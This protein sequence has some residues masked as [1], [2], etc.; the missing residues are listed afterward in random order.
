MSRPPPLTL[1]S[2]TIVPQEFVQSILSERWADV[3]QFEIVDRS[4]LV[5]ELLR[6]FRPIDCCI[7]N[8]LAVK[9]RARV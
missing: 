2:H 8:I 5:A 7:V 4:K 6:H 3:A 9:P 1:C